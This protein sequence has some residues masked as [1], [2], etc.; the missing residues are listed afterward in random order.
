MTQRPG[1]ESDSKQQEATEGSLWEE[2]VRWDL[3]EEGLARPCRAHGVRQLQRPCK[4]AS[5][6]IDGADGVLHCLVC[7]LM[8]DAGHL[9]QHIGHSICHILIL[10]QLQG[11]QVPAS[12]QCVHGL[13]RLEQRRRSDDDG[14]KWTSGTR[15]LHVD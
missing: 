12:S 8:I 6:S 4:A 2:C 11:M 13:Q 9:L 5:S 15:Y 7:T 1:A 3:D 14:S 10:E